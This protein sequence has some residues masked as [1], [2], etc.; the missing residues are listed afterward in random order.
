MSMSRTLVA[1]MAIGVALPA[2]AKTADSLE[3]YRQMTTVEPRCARPGSDPEIIVCG[4][5][6]AD[7]WRVPYIGY[8]AGDPRSETVSGER[9]RLASERKLPC[10]IGAVLAGC[11][12]V[13]VSVGTNFS[14]DKLKL[15]P[16]GP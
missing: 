5:R 10:G 3:N 11:G 7:R 2:S 12:M 4:H 16:I 6:R 13:G 14:P 15:R 8:D 1:A 9:N